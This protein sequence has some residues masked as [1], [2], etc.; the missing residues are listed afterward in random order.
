MIAGTH[1][2]G[3]QATR[4]D[5]GSAQLRMGTCP[6]DLFY[7]KPELIQTLESY[8]KDVLTTFA[9]D[10]RIVFWICTTKPETAIT[11]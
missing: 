5:T 1:I 6:G 11:G 3:R 7:E 9:D 2:S 4:P 10:K 8:V